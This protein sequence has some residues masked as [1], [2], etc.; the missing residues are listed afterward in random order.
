M[1]TDLRT[2]PLRSNS[3]TQPTIRSQVTMAIRV[4]I[5]GY[6]FSTKCFHLPFILP[7][8]DLEVIA[9][10][11]RAPAPTNPNDAP[12]WGHCTID[13]PKAKH[14][15][16]A[17]EFFADEDIELVLVLTSTAHGEYAEK[18]LLAGKHVVV[19]KPFVATSAEADK[20]IALAQEKGKILTVYHNRRF[21]SDFRTVRHL[22]ESGALGDILEADIHFDYPDPGWISHWTSKEYIPGEGMLFALG[23]HTIDQALVLFGRPSSVTAFLRSNRGIDSAID[24]TFTIILQYSGEKKNLLVTIKTASVTHMR[25]QLRFFVRGTRGT[26]LKFG[27]DPQEDQAIAAPGQPA[28]SPETGV[29]DQRIWGTLTT[30]DPIPDHPDPSLKPLDYQ[31]TAKYHIA[32]YPSFPGWYR[33]YYENIVAAIRGETEVFVKPE[34]ARDGLRIIELARESHETG[35]TVPWS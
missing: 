30:L 2:S 29:E 1:V 34:T 19:E 8:P 31:K 12:R 6:G 9:F 17:D 27:T 3:D 10:L 25:D 16:T 22:V 13:F 20:L 4:G 28:I 5:V 32:R 24:D 15:R 21:D 23:T 7:N 35:R 18:A 26:F 33:G 14:Y 11:Q